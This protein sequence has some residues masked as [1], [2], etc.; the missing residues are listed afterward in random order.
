MRAG[1]TPVVFFAAIFGPML[2]FRPGDTAEYWAWPISPA[3]SAAWIG[4]GYTFVALV[5]AAVLLSGRWTA[6]IVPLVALCP[7]SVVMLAAAALESD[8]FFTTS[9]SF[10]L[11]ISVHVLLV[12]LLPV[13]YATRRS[14][15][16]GRRPSDSRLPLRLCAVLILVGAITAIIG[17]LL[18]TSPAALDQS[19]PWEMDPLTSRVIGG[20][21]LLPA[22]GMLCAVFEKRY[23]AYRLVLPLAAVWFG[24][25]LIASLF[26]RG[27]LRSGTVPTSYIVLLGVLALTSS[28][29]ALVLELRQRVQEHAYAYTLSHFAAAAQEA[30][31]ATSR[32]A[33]RR[34][35]RRGPR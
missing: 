28:G 14:H 26:N 4:A 23:A 3:M 15:D 34:R 33:L 12:L 13:M 10:Y 5:V 6:A 17:I 9:M 1:L 19:W 22:A 30:R 29:L 25:L 18:I 32:R 7:F 8:H 31:P 21:L 35:A 11:W 27:D 2:L 16:P 24:L 20:W